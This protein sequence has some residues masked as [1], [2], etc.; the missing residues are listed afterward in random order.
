MGGQSIVQQYVEIEGQT[1]GEALEHGLEEL[2]VSRDQVNVKVIREPTKG[3]FGLGAKEAKVRL[4]LKQGVSSTPE[5]IM[6]EILARMGVNAKIKSQIIDG[7]TH[8]VINADTP[9]LLIGRHGQTL[10]AL[11]HILN[12]ILNKSS[13]VK[14]KVFVD[15]EG[16]RERR[17]QMLMDLAYRV[18][19][20]VRQTNQEIVL[21]PMPPQ[22]RRIIHTAL[23]SDEH[24]RTYSRGGGV[25]K[26][27][28]VTP[29]DQYE[30]G[31]KEYAS[32]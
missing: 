30:A 11:E 27:V 19:T 6:T 22:D 14:K 1:T 20:K 25:M 4:T 7:S 29:K 31:R 8:L 21:D 15:A 28:A 12:C 18:A 24:V 3:I 9:G 32:E 26:R 10:N 13:L 17:E 16:Y 2:G 5:A 23:H